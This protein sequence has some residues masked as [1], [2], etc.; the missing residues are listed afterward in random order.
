MSPSIVAAHRTEPTP[1]RAGVV[2]F[3]A[4]GAARHHLAIGR[5]G[6]PTNITTAQPSPETPDEAGLGLV[7]MP[8]LQ[9]RAIQTP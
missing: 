6:R 5:P 1:R 3:E 9:D 4:I 8:S 2:V 7:P